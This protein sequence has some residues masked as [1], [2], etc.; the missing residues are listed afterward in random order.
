MNMG[1]A[2]ELKTVFVS[3]CKHVNFCYKIEQLNMEVYGIDSILEP[4]SSG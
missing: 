4:A 2:R 1:L 3:G